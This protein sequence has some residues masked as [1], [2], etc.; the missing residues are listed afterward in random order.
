MQRVIIIPDQVV[1]IEVIEHFQ[2]VPGQEPDPSELA[3]YDGKL[4]QVSEWGWEYI[5]NME[6]DPGET[7]RG[8]WDGKGLI[9]DETADYIR[10]PKDGW[11]LE[12]IRRV[13]GKDAI[14]GPIYAGDEVIGAD[15]M[16]MILQ[17]QIEEVSQ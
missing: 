4:E 6:L 13:I 1:T 17:Q 7:L 3:P 9:E 16:N 15:E 14:G 5:Y 2:V 10:L 8:E 11:H 12:E